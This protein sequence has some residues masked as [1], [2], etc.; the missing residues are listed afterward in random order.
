MK[1]ALVIQ[2][3]PTNAYLLVRLLTR[4][5]YQVVQAVDAQ[6]AWEYACQ[7]GS[8][9]VV[10]DNGLASEPA[11]DLCRRLKAAGSDLRVILLGGRGDEVSRARARAAG[12]EDVLNKPFQL[13]DLADCLIAA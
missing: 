4:W 10:V 2:D 3:D 11:L 7:W 6:Q 1:R 13:R 12:A 5:G 8:G 9:L